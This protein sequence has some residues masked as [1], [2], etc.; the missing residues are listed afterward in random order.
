LSSGLKTTFQKGYE[1]IKNIFPELTTEIK[2]NKA[3]E[4]Y[5]WLGEVGGLREWIDERTPK[6]LA[7][8]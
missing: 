7:E 5:G 1:G 3:S 4:E 6:A 2:S 8:N